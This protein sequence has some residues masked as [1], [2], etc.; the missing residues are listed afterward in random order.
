MY[1]NQGEDS[2]ALAYFDKSLQAATVDS[3]T[4]IQNYQELV[5]YYFENGS[6]IETGQYLDRLLS[7]FDPSSTRYKQLSRSVVH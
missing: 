3:Y 2:L 7:F 4:E 6:Y 5:R 1:L